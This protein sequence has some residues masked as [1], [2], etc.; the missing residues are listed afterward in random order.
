MILQ[1]ERQFLRRR[2]VQRAFAVRGGAGELDVVLYQH[3]VVKNGRACGTRQLS[4]RV[5]TR[6][7][8]N[9]VV[10]LPFARRTRGVHQRRIL[11]IN[12]RGLAIG[13]RLALIGIEDLSLVES[14]QENAAVAAVLVFAFRGGRLGKFHVQLAI[15]KRFACLNVPGLW[16]NLEVAVLDFPFG[17]AAVLFLVH[18]E[19]SLP[20]N[21]ATASEGARP[22]ASCVLAV[23][24]SI[25]GGTGRLR[26]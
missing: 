17:G 25:T 9:N 21:S 8:K 26:S 1:R 4:C 12:R 22:G 23:P 15:A 20:S 24:G 14:L 3:A 6:T 18:C 5:K 2:F 16:H 11:A 10:G 13:I 7:V 19:R